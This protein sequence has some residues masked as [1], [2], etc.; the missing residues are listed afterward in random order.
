ML[1]N[2]QLP[3]G[4]IKGCP[5]TSFK[6]SGGEHEV[7]ECGNRTARESIEVRALVFSNGGE[8]EE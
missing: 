6:Q 1:T 7:G 8:G 4:H 3:L 2:T 5:H